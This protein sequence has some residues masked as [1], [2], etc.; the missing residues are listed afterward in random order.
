MLIRFWRDVRATTVIEYGLG[1]GL[2][3]IAVVVGAM[4]IGSKLA[5]Y[6][7]KINGNLN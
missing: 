2:I 3:S 4:S 7:G 1:A 6:Y 5:G